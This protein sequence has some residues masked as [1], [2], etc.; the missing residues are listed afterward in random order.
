METDKQPTPPHSSNAFSDG[1]NAHR[2]STTAEESS[3]ASKSSEQLCEISSSAVAKS[4]APDT[5]GSDAVTQ[6]KPSTPEAPA[7]TT[8]TTGPPVSFRSRGFRGAHASF[9]LRMLQEQHG[10]EPVP[11]FS[12]T[13]IFLISVA[14]LECLSQLAAL[15]IILKFI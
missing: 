8:S 14:C 4:T 10:F 1:F 5:A 11:S 15:S 9:R 2:L 3:I 12:N 13:V 6:T 7:T